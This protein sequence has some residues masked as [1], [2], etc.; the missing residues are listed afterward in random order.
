MTGASCSLVT[1]FI[2]VVHQRPYFLT[3]DDDDDCKDNDELC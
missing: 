2:V 1:D 3:Y